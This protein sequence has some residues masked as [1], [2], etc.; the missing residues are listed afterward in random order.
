MKAFF[1]LLSEKT[2][3]LNQWQGFIIL[4]VIVLAVLIAAI[5]L[6]W[7]AIHA[8]STLSQV[9]RYFFK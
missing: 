9:W 8:P 2:P 7:I 3:K 5:A 1:E 4:L 6:L